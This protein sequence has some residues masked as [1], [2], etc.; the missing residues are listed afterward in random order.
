MTTVAA[1]ARAPL[2]RRIERLREQIR[3][4]DY[5]YYVLDRPTIGDAAYDA[6]LRELVGLEARYPKLVTPDSPTQ[7]V[8]GGLRP[9]FRTRPHRAPLLS[10]DSTTDADAV[11]QFDL[12]LRSTLGR[13][14]DYVLEPKFDGLSIEI[15]YKHGALAWAATR[16]DG[17]RGED[18]TANIRTIRTVPLR[19]RG[20]SL[21]RLLAVRGEVLMRRADFEALNKRLER[22]GEPPFANPRNAA[23]GSVRQLDP[24]VTARRA[25]RVY[26]YDVINIVGRSDQPASAIEQGRWMRDQGL[27]V[28][29]LRH[30]GSTAADI[31]AY[32]D[33][34]AKLRDTLD[35]EID[36]I[37]AK[38]GDLEARER[39]GATSRHPRWAIG[40]KFP[41]RSAITRLE[42]IAVQ[43]G[44]T[45]ALTPVAILRPVH[46]GG[47]RVARATLH[48]WNEV[49][50]LGIRPGD[51]V[52]VI[53]A[54]DVIPEIVSRVRPA[55]RR[56]NRMH[57][58]PS[59]CPSCHARVVVRGPQRICPNSLACPA[60]RKSAIAHFASRDAFDIK[61]LGPS[62]IQLL[63]DHGMVRAPAD[64]FVLTGDDLRALPRFGAV[65]AARL[66]DA[67]QSAR[68]VTLARFLYALGIPDMGAATATRLASHFKTLAHI[69]RADVNRLAAVVGPATARQIAEFFARPASEAAIADLLRH[70]TIVER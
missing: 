69:R 54:G 15:V 48:N 49:S 35:V 62:T 65:A 30:R 45:G 59:R 26:F 11:R 13:A 22:D 53:R 17:E 21:P 23:A 10:L 14:V 5:R 1:A 58:P 61:G 41:A 60:Q 8:A 28:S 27:R 2:M 56:A 38:V 31:L 19:L 67:I 9:G 39:L 43:V 70:I 47:V 12:R 7:R 36:G 20:A 63:I 40:V 52:E 51:T 57:G 24:T 33:R 29:P 64:L 68:H 66:G 32:R 16:G 37:V 4:H 46:I 55:R 44:R 6:L 50:R 25:L 42:R 18:V 34:I 3:K